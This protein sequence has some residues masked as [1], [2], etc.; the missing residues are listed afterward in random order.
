M[1]GYLNRIFGQVRHIF[2]INFI[3]Y[4][5]NEIFIVDTSCQKLIFSKNIIKM[6]KRVWVSHVFFVCIITIILFFGIVIVML[7]SRFL[8]HQFFFVLILYLAAET[9]DES[10]SEII[11]IFLDLHQHQIWSFD[12][13]QKKK[14]SETK[15]YAA[16]SIKKY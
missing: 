5:L 12:M 15:D 10:F 1:S 14:W 13:K 9:W 3:W 8:F 4:H 6:N 11:Y 16:Y 7:N 2:Y